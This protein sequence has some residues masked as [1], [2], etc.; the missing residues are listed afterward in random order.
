MLESV[1]RWHRGRVIRRHP[2]SDPAW[3]GVVARV[4]FLAH[5]SAHESDRL[6][7]WVALFLDRKRIHGAGGFEVDEL[8]RLLVASQACLLILNLDLD[9]YRDWVEVIVYPAE[10]VPDR[11]Y[12]DAAGVVHRVREP[13]AGESW[14][15]GPVILSAQD[16]EPGWYDDGAVVN[17]VIH[18]FAHKL[19][20]LNGDANGMPP[21]QPGMDREQWS[22]AFDAAYRDLCRRAD[23]GGPTP[24]DAYAAESPG[25][26]FAVACEYFFQ[27]P[28]RLNSAYPE[29]YRQLARFY[30]QDP[31]ARAGGE[32]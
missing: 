20:M 30:R 14:L 7:Q 13:L 4:P 18:E 15:Q 1:K 12:V 25:E 19:D 31:A 26:F 24:M 3:A 9:Y 2:V 23:R 5:L 17:V 8:A 16:L 27:A 21:L 32:P 22:A 6:R 28:D 11:E 10:F 29:V